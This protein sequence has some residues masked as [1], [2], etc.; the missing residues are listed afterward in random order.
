MAN[1]VTTTFRGE[2]QLSGVTNKIGQSF[3]GL[4]QRISGAGTNAANSSGLFGKVGSALGN[5]AQIAA[6]IIAADLFGK[7]ARGIRDLGVGAVTTAIQFES[8]FAGVGKTV[9]GIMTDTGQLTT[10]GQQMRNAFIDL[11]T[12]MP[13]SFV[14]LSKIGEVAGQLGIGKDSLVDFTKTAAM[15]GDT[16]NVSADTAATAMGRMA[17]IFQAQLSEAGISADEMASRTGSAVVDL[18][19][20]FATT[21]SEI[22]NFAERISGAGAVAGLT[23]P[24]VLGIGAAMS[25]VGVEAEAGGTAVQKVLMGMNNAVNASATGFTDYSKE[26][27]N[28]S[29]KMIKLNADSARLEAQFPGLQDELL[30]QYDAFI[31]A[32]G[33]AE[34]FGRQLG[35]KTRQKAFETANGLRDLTGELTLLQNE[36]GKPIDSGQLAK[37]ASVAGMSA[38]EF[39]T[40]WETDAAGAFNAFVL[41]LEKE[42]DNAV[43]ILGDLD[44]EDQRLIRS[45]LSLSNA[46][47]LLTRTLDTS[48]TA[49]D[50]NTALAIEAQ[51]RYAT[52]ESQVAMFKNSIKALGDMLGSSFL[53]I[54]NNVAGGIKDFAVTIIGAA[55]AGG[56]FGSGGILETLGFTPKTVDMIY[57]I[58]KPIIDFFSNLGKSFNVDTI[59]AGW[60]GLVEIIS[61]FL[62]LFSGDSFAIFDFIQ[63]LSNL[64][65]DT[66]SIVAFASAFTT[67]Q[68]AIANLQAAWEGGGISG[69]LTTLGEMLQSGWDTYVSPV[70]QGWIDAATKWIID[71]IPTIPDKLNQLLTSINT[72]LAEGAPQI[73]TS[74]AGWVEA[75]WGWV[76]T[77]I[78]GVGAALGVLLVAIGAWATSGEAQTKLNEFGQNL[79][80]LLADGIVLLFENAG[81]IATVLGKVVAGLAAGVAGVM[82][83]LAVTGGQ[84]AA[85]IIAGILEKLGVD[86]QPALFSELGGIF[87][88]MWENL[89]TIAA[90]LGAPI[91]QGFNEGILN[92]VT[93]IVNG[94]ANLALAVINAIKAEF[95]IASPSTVFAEIG[96]NLI[97]GLVEGITSNI[98][99]A[100]SA[101]G[102]IFSGLFGGGEGE[103]PTFDFAGLIADL[104]VNIPAGIT[105]VQTFFTTLITTATELLNVFLT[106]PLFNFGVMLTTLYATT[107]PTLQV[108]W[109][110]M[111]NT[112]IVSTNAV[113]TVVT[114]LD[115]IL[116]QVQST[117]LAMATTVISKNKDVGSSFKGVADRINS[118]LI[119]AIRK[120]TQEYEKMAAAA[121]RAARAGRDAGGGGGGFGGGQASGGPIFPGISYL[122]GEEGPEIITPTRQAYVN[123][124]PGPGQRGGDTYNLNIYNPTGPVDD[125]VQNFGLLRALRGGT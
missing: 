76:D 16:T 110:T 112:A 3:D 80:K 14:E 33:S 9:D 43:N 71:T 93:E 58:S 22:F 113:I 15:M 117:F 31:A 88:G 27:E 35:D 53:P 59:K 106:G 25:S 101:I 12:T 124:N 45:F 37:F 102:S 11:S 24:D 90:T 109:Q 95:G 5:I 29:S 28:T 54:I 17:N 100:M 87:S 69:L 52:T 72:W 56:I 49:W 96:A 8:A 61:G 122:V 123:P 41:G 111:S 121:E 34:D 94:V 63:G 64:G 125:M 66:A 60:S 97:L 67:I 65:F 39:K 73:Q 79:G 21:E 23:I 46:G 75:F 42:G 84:I 36:T 62:K 116:R 2:D 82:G 18:G 26:I 50:E 32:G 19:N 70:L 103:G 48:N 57:Q 44:L 13:T 115:N 51:K 118:D 98:G 10:A 105:A 7:I 6:G 30:G 99:T 92:G 86:V 81:N 114:A 38:D 107:I 119:P 91:V 4:G 20:K 55:R 77:A 85:G 1:T 68:T 78:T 40:A 47:D 120:A 74:V 108:T 104:T 89:K 83:L